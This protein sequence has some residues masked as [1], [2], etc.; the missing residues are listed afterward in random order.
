[1]KLRSHRS[2]KRLLPLLGV[3]CVIGLPPACLSQGS[4]L[5][6][7]QTSASPITFEFGKGS[8]PLDGPWQFHLGDDLLWAY[9]EIDDSTNHIGWEQITTD[10][11][12]GAQTHP[13]YTGYT[14]Y[15]RHLHLIPATSGDQTLA[16]FMPHVDDVYEV[17][18]NGNLIGSRGKMPPHG[19]RIYQV[20]PAEFTLGQAQDGVL[21][22]R[23]WKMP[24]FFDDSASLGGLAPPPI[25]GN[26][27]EI[28]AVSAQE[29]SQWLRGQ[30]LGWAIAAIFA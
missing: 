27:F 30:M 19:Q 10:K 11:T 18:W 7:A 2:I 4:I 29:D 13:A 24:L 22:I 5:T 1:M 9:P 21:A 6:T 17:Y 20:P 16:I 26:V 25:I 15:R 14:W 12:W 23:V 8:I 28:H 3:F